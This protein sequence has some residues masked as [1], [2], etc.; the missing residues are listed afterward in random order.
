[1]L[2]G[3]TAHI[4]CAVEMNLDDRVEV[5]RRHFEEDLVA[6]DAGIVDHAV[7]AAKGFD[8]GGDDVVG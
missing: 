3:G 2:S 5:L 1:V 7:D 8:R 4:E 6:Q